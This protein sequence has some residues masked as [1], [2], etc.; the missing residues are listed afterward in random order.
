MSENTER[1]ANLLQP[2]KELAENW[3]IDIAAELEE[4]LEELEKVTFEFDEGDDGKKTTFSFA[5]AALV[6]QSSACV[7]SRK[8]EHLY[9]LV[10]NTLNVLFA[11]RLAF[12]LHSLHFCYVFSF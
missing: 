4:Y 7:Y 6:I 9:N 12:I 11:K 1:Y 10:Y 2:I 3:D 5:E 8:V